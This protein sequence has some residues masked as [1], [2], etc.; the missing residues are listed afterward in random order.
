MQQSSEDLALHSKTCPLEKS[1]YGLI[2]KESTERDPIQP[3]AT[4]LPRCQAEQIPD[5]SQQECDQPKIKE[6]WNIHSRCFI[7]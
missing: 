7:R 5:Q 4:K 1:E 6:Q 3:E 2:A